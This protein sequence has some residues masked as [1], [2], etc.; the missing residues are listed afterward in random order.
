M[1][2]LFGAVMNLKKVQTEATLLHVWNFWRNFNS[3]LQKYNCPS[4]ANQ[5]S[6]TYQNEM[7]EYCAQEIVNVT[8]EITKSGMYAIMTDETNAGQSE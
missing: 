2:S 4:N 8:S 7:I 5:I 6:P 3:F 1:G